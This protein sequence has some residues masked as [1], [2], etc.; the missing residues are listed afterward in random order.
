METETLVHGE[1]R[2]MERVVFTSRRSSLAI[3]LARGC[4][5]RL[6]YTERATYVL[7]MQMNSHAQ[8]LHRHRCRDDLPILPLPTGDSASVVLY[9]KMLPRAQL[10]AAVCPSQK[11]RVDGNAI[12]SGLNTRGCGVA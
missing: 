9:V 11:F 10:T 5:S 4:V 12:V 3:K 7:R 8:T 2:A 6:L 1:L